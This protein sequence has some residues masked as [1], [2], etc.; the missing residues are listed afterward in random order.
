MS[1]SSFFYRKKVHCN[2]CYQPVGDEANYSQGDY[3]ICEKC[4]NTNKNDL[5]NIQSNKDHGIFSSVV[6]YVTSFFP[7]STDTND[8]TD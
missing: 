4:M 6:N 2:I 8:E 1:Y 7:N 5:V 3:I